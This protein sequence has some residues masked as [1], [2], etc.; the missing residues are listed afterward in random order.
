MLSSIP[1][2]RTNDHETRHHIDCRGRR[3]R[4]AVIGADCGRAMQLRT[5]RRTNGNFRQRSTRRG[6]SRTMSTLDNPILAAGL[7]RSSPWYTLVA[8][9]PLGSNVDAIVGDPVNNSGCLE[10]RL[11]D[12]A[13]RDD[14]RG[15]PDQSEQPRGRSQRLPGVLRLHRPQRRHRLGVLLVRRRR[16]TWGNVQV[17]GLTAETGGQGTSRR[18]TRP[19]IRSWRSARTA[20]PTTPTSCSAG[21][22]RRRRSP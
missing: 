6:H 7:C 9:G 3:V 21:S 15:Q 13:E 1:N 16:D 12:A 2:W 19:A 4:G 20:S 14:D 11:H 17:P 22:S 18:S 10:P 5:C 8:Y